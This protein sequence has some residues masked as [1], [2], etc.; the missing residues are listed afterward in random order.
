MEHG[1]RMNL[2]FLNLLIV[3]HSDLCRFYHHIKHQCY[4]NVACCLTFREFCQQ[5]VRT[6]R[7]TGI[8][9]PDRPRFFEQAGKNDSVEM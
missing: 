5:I 9:M 6:C 2:N 8:Q 3:N 4:R 1:I 7:S